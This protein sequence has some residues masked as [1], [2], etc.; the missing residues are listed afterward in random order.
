MLL[1]AG[2]MD[3]MELLEQFHLIHDTSQQQYQG[4][5]PEAVNSHM[6]LMMG[7]DIA[8]NM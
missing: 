6:L 2:I 3:E 8:R 7:E 1:P 5:L 4:T